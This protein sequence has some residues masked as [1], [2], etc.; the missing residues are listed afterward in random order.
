MPQPASQER[1]IIASDKTRL[2]AV[3]AIAQRNSP[4]SDPSFIKA[5]L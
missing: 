3:S 2:M 5:L 1:P 4:A